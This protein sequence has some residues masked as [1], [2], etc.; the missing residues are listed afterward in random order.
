MRQLTLYTGGGVSLS[1]FD[2]ENR[3]VSAYVRLLAAEGMGITDGNIVTA[4]VDTLQP[5]LWH[6]CP[7][8]EEE[9]TED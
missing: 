3:R 6:D 4:C 8:P 7:L 5:G 9:E 1:P 2:G